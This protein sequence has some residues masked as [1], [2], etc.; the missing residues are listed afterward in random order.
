MFESGNSKSQWP[1]ATGAFRALGFAD[2][3]KS[4]WLCCKFPALFMQLKLIGERTLPIEKEFLEFAAHLSHIDGNYD[5][6]G[7]CRSH[8]QRSFF[9]RKMFFIE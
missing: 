4:Q 2:H 6:R 8:V 7:G 5:R 3:R 9:F 1:G